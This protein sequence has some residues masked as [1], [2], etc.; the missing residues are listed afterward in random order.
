MRFEFEV[1]HIGESEGERGRGDGTWSGVE[2]SGV[3]WSGVYVG[4]ICD[5]L[6]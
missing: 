4:E 6:M 1:A 5:R 3:E 2:W